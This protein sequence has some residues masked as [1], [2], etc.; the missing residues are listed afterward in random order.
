MSYF[1]RYRDAHFACALCDDAD[2]LARGTEHAFSSAAG[3]SQ[4]LRTVHHVSTS[5]SRVSLALNFKPVRVGEQTAQFLDFDWSS[6]DPNHDW[7]ELSISPTESPPGDW[8]DQNEFE[9]EGEEGKYRGKRRGQSLQIPP[10]MRIAGRVT[11]AGQFQ[12]TT[13]DEK[14]QAALDETGERSKLRYKQT[15]VRRDES[16]FPLLKPAASSGIPVVA[17]SSSDIITK[18]KIRGNEKNGLPTV[19]SSSSLDAII[20]SVHTTSNLSKS[21]INNNDN[22]NSQLNQQLNQNNH[23]KRQIELAEAFGVKSVSS[24][25]SKLMKNTTKSFQNVENF[26]YYSETLSWIDPVLAEGDW[27]TEKKWDLILR[28]LF[29]PGLITFARNSKAELLKIEKK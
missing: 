7:H 17:G 12:Y 1:H 15:P 20:N 25:A 4:H 5:G 29:L 26:E 28:P 9:Y 18:S 27:E 6:S 21:N 22:K 13:E 16:Q 19:S 14:L 11:G 10:N 2:L 23:I 8:G 24:V 3:L